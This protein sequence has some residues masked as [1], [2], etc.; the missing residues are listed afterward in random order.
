MG[1][2]SNT[3]DKLYTCDEIAEKFGVKKITV[4]RWI[5]EKKLGAVNIGKGYRIRENDIE[6]FINS[7]LTVE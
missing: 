5:R 6:Q 1:N 7:R 4:W 3:S 2:I